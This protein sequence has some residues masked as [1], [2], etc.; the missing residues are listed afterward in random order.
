MGEIAHKLR[1]LSTF[2]VLSSIPSNH[3]MAHNHLY[4]VLMPSFGHRQNAVYIINKEKKKKKPGV[5]VHA[6]NVSRGKK[7]SSGNYRTHCETSLPSIPAVLP[8]NFFFQVCSN[9]HII[10]NLPQSF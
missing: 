2:Q 4:W 8:V 7:R 5:L 6:F 3:M 9:R 1:A 10:R